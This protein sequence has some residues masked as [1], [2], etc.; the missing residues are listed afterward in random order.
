MLG[1]GASGKSRF[2]RELSEATGIPRTELDT[3]F[4]SSGPVAAPSERWCEIQRELANAIRWILDG[5][6]GPNDALEVRLLR[7]DTIVMFDL[8]TVVCA[9]R[10]VRRSRERLDFWRWLFTW[11][12]QFR[13]KTFDAIKAYAPA[14]ELLMVRSR[15]DRNRVLR[16]LS[17]PDGPR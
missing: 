3:I 10:A 14:A 16:Y 11:R 5:D 7:A 15:A 2:S 4:W 9:W 6:L 8:P 12:R 17:R 1:N 13:P